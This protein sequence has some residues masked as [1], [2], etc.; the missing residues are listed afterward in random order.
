MKEKLFDDNQDKDDV[1]DADE[2]DI[3]DN[4]EVSIVEMLHLFST[5]DVPDNNITKRQR[6]AFNKLA[7]GYIGKT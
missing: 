1:D 3:D 6:I 2:E 5:S 4:V 7:F